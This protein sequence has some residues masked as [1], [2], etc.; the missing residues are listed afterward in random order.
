[1]DSDKFSSE[2]QSWMLESG[3]VKELKTRLRKE[4]YEMLLARKTKNINIKN[5]KKSKKCWSDFDLAMNLLIVEHL[6]QRGL[7]YTASVMV[8]EA[9]FLEEPPEIEVV[10]STKKCPNSDRLAEYKRQSPSKLPDETVS[11]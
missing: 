4:M 1:M 9:E 7:W 11:I 2:I 5:D 6:M 3:A 8:S 10:T